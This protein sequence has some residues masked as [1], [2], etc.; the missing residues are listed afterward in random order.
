MIIKDI[1]YELFEKEKKSLI[2]FFSEL[3]LNSNLT[4]NFLK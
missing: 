2:I 4:M 3:K 1:I